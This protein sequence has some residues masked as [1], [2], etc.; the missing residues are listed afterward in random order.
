MNLGIKI[1]ITAVIL[2][3]IAFLE[4]YAR[5][6]EG[7]SIYGKKFIR[8]TYTLVGTISLLTIWLS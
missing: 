4:R 6:G 5:R 3:I 8:W 2:V 7:L 1:A